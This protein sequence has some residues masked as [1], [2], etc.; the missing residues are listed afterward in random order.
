MWRSP[1]S[2]GAIDFSRLNQAMG[3]EKG[4]SKV[5]SQKAK[6]KSVP[7]HKFYTGCTFDF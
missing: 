2:G 3:E 1:S 5:K 6:V 4:K 7:A